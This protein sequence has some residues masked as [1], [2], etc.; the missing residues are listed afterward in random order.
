MYPYRTPSFFYFSKTK[1]KTKTKTILVS[2]SH[3]RLDGTKTVRAGF[4]ERTR[5]RT[6][7]TDLLA[8]DSETCNRDGANW[9]WSRFEKF[10]ARERT[11]GGSVPLL[12]TR[13]TWTQVRGCKV[14]KQQSSRESMVRYILR[15][16][17][18]PLSGCASSSLYS[19]SHPFNPFNSRRSQAWHLDTVTT[20]VAYRRQ[21]LYRYLYSG[22]YQFAAI[23]YGVREGFADLRTL[24]ATSTHASRLNR[25]AARLFSP[26]A[27]H[28]NL[29]DLVGFSSR[30]SCK[31]QLSGD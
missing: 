17:T 1:T 18:A 6:N 12:I 5:H 11:I 28:E 13:D 16:I 27:A 7:F 24:A 8:L 4:G 2:I 23:H 30:A 3:S 14:L 31:I 15:N 21:R 26:Y 25:I 20:V 9:K 19:N 22:N 10:H 29:F